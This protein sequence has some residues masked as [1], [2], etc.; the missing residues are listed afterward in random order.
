MDVSDE[1]LIRKFA[2]LQTKGGSSQ[3]I[4]SI[5]SSAASVRNWEWCVLAKVCTDRPVFTDQFEK[6]MRRA[7]GP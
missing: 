7:W 4:V 2:G 6:Q 3:T 1:D 5:P